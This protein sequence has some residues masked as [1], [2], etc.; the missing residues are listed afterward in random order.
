MSLASPTGKLLD[1]V[2]QFIC[3]KDKYAQTDSRKNAF[4]GQPL[5]VQVIFFVHVVEDL[6]IRH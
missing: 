2:I 6:D 5:S 4:V 3:L 1:Q